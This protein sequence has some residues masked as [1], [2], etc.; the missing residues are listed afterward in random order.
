M[1]KIMGLFVATSQPAPEEVGRRLAAQRR[2]YLALF[3]QMKAELDQI[4]TPVRPRHN[5]RPSRSSVTG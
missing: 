3:G 2:P 4:P 5:L 1:P